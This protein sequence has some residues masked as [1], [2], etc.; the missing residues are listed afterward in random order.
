MPQYETGTWNQ[1][2]APF[3]AS[4]TNKRELPVRQVEAFSKA[5]PKVKGGFSLGNQ[6]NHYRT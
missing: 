3:N 6:G 4:T 1:K 5:E 2:N